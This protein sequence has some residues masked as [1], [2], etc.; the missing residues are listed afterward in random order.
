[1]VLQAPAAWS[2]VLLLSRTTAAAAALIYHVANACRLSAAGRHLG[3]LGGALIIG[4]P[5]VVG[6][7]LFVGSG[8]LT[9]WRAALVFVARV[10]VVFG[11]NEVVANALSVATKRT[12]LRPLKAHLALLVVAAAVIAAPGIAAY[13]SSTTVAAWP[14]VLRLV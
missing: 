4:T 11:F 5:Y 2:D 7:L 13:G 10:F 6:S 14:G 9:A 3:A 1:A 12:P 8:V